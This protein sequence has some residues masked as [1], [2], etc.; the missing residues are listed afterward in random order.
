MIKKYKITYRAIKNFR[1]IIM[2]GLSEEDVRR[3]F[4]SS[5]P[6]KRIVSIEVTS[7]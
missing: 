6:K 7:I 5:Y 4:V 1:T 2:S 3:R